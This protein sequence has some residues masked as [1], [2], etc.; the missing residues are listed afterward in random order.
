MYSLHWHLQI[1]PRILEVVVVVVSSGSCE[2][3]CGSKTQQDCSCHF[4][5]IGTD[6]CCLDFQQTC[7]DEYSK[8]GTV[9]HCRLD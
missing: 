3:K 5:C 9:G 2:G 1:W 8:R 7:P 4:S 6:T